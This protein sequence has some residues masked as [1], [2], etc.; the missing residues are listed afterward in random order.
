MCPSQGKLP[1][2]KSMWLM[3]SSD[4][5]TR[6]RCRTRSPSTELPRI[7]MH[8]DTWLVSK[9]KR[10]WSHTSIR[11][12]GGTW[13]NQ[14]SSNQPLQFSRWS[15]R[16]ADWEIW[17]KDHRWRPTMASLRSVIWITDTNSHLQTW[18][19]FQSLRVIR[20]VELAKACT[21]GTTLG[22][23]VLSTCDLKWIAIKYMT[24]VGMVPTA[25]P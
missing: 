15:L 25:S 16:R 7:S 12:I 3:S 5:M 2:R 4:G 9:D 17:T 21:W 11:S 22:R 1:S 10:D 19:K 23:G 6:I 18:M 13:N 20:R 8:Q 14:L 24:T